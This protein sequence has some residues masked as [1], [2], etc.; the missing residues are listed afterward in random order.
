MVLCLDG[1]LDGVYSA[2]EENFY[3]RDCFGRRGL[4]RV[5]EEDTA[6]VVGDRI[7]GR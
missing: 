1:W 7:R 5:C 3:G 2:V 4:T 6:F